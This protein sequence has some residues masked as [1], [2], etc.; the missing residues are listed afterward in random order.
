MLPPI[1]FGM[2]EMDSVWRLDFEEVI[3]RLTRLAPSG[4]RD[5]ARQASSASEFD[6]Q[7]E[8][9]EPRILDRIVH[10]SKAHRLEVCDRGTKQ[11]MV[12]EA[13]DISP[14]STPIVSDGPKAV[15]LNMAKSRL[16][17]IHLPTQLCL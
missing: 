8:P 5:W 10:R 9:D 2:G 4:G 17:R 11:G 6:F 15:L 7:S 14:N 13:E 3:T 16:R 12:E 1:D